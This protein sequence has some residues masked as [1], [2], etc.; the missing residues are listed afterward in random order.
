MT[1][2]FMIDH[3]FTIK[4]FCQAHKI[5]RASLYNLWSA[6]HGPPVIKVG[7]RVL[8]SAEAAEDWRRQLEHPRPHRQSA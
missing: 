7:A 5:C 1:G 2:T 4:E 6:G 8:I 3:T